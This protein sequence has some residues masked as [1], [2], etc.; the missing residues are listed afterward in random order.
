[1]A[2][3]RTGEILRKTAETEIQLQL[4]LDGSGQHQIDT[5]IPFFSHMLT[6]FSV[7]SLCDLKVV[8][9][10]DIA[11]DDHHTVEDVGICLGQALK[12]ALKE[13]K[14]ITRYGEATVPMDEAL[15]RVVLDLSGRSYLVYNVELNRERI[16]NFATE[17]GKEFFQAVANNAG[18]NLHIDLIR[19]KN[20]HHILEAVFKAFGRALKKAITI[21]PR[22]EG[23][24]SSKKIL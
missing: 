10:G 7:H 23:V 13:K 21:E 15:V 4:A 19:G 3:E 1:M 8:A 12:M 17:N 22:I 14:G 18:M 20:D 16:G 5:E 9:K 11:V 2:E 6:L 24:W